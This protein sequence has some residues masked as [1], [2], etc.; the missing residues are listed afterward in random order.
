[1]TVASDELAPGSRIDRYV[2]DKMLGAGGMGT[3]YRAHHAHMGNPVALKVLRPGTASDPQALDRFLR[4]AKASALSGSPHIV[5]VLDFGFVDGEGGTA[6][7]VMELLEGRELWDMMR[8]TGPLPV[9]RAV[10]ITLQILEGV[11]AAHAAGIVHRDLKPQNVFLTKQPDGTE[12]AKLLDFGISKII[13]GASVEHLTRT[14]V[15]LGTPMYMAPEQF[16]GSREIDKRADLYSVCVILYEMLSRALP[17]EA[18]TLSELV[19]AVTSAPPTPL[20]E[21]LPTA[22]KQLIDIVHRGLDRDPNRRWQ[23][24]QELAAALRAVPLSPGASATA[25]APHASTTGPTTGPVPGQGAAPGPSALAATQA[26]WTAGAPPPLAGPTPVTNRALPAPV[27][28]GPVASQPFSAGPPMGAPLAG[29][30]AAPASSA[31]NRTLYIVLGV[32][33]LLL[34]LGCIVPCVGCYGLSILGSVAQQAQ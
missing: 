34:V 26:A 18:D 28:T 31:N 29:P 22:P 19:V 17:H 8:G 4:E 13:E 11:G 9:E 16:L 20:S 24:A 15:L 14:G 5:R 10:G 7:L 30:A 6:F 23:S 3:V 33:G 2:I 25:A 12:L 1:M 27:A 21:F 32:V